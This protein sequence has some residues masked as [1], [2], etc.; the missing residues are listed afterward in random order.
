GCAL[1]LGHNP[2]FH[3]LANR[4]LRDGGIDEFVTCAVVR[5]DLDVAFWGEVEAG[6]GRLREHFWPRQLRREP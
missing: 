5:L 3:D 4:L 6:C 1:I 2:G